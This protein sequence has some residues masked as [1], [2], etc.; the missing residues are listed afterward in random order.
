MVTPTTGIAKFKSLNGANVYAVAFY[1][2][3]VVGAKATFASVGAAGTS[4]ET[5][6]K[7][8]EDCYLFDVSIKTGPTVAVGFYPQSNNKPIV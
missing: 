7:A 6:W 3:D 8:E 2:S 5:F 4:D 1:V